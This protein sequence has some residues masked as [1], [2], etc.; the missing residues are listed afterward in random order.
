MWRR[1][2][3]DGR[4]RSG[5]LKRAGPEQLT[6]YPQVWGGSRGGRRKRSGLRTNRKAR[7]YARKIIPPFVDT[8]IN[9]MRVVQKIKVCVDRRELARVGT[10]RRDMSIPHVAARSPFT[11]PFSAV[12]FCPFQHSTDAKVED[13]TAHLDGVDRLK[14]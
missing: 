11:S 12:Y 9:T 13:F 8:C 6:P 7:D 14:S 2:N 5:G 3:E 10:S 4:G 1:A